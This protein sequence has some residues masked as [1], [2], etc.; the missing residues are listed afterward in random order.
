[1]G[2]AGK[3]TFGTVLDVVDTK[4]NDRIALKVEICTQEPCNTIVDATVAPL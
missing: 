2:L 4:Y 3:G 1:M